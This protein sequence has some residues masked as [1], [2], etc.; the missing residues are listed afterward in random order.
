MQAGRKTKLSEAS[1]RESSGGIRRERERERDLDHAK[2][3]TMSGKN[4]RFVADE[5]V[6]FG[7]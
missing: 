6:E 4:R 5:A 2:K 1:G 3:A 7:K